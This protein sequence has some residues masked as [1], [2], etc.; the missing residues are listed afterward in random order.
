MKKLYVGNL[1]YTSTE[2]EIRELFENHGEVESVN[3]IM[4]RETG[5]AR[6]FAFVEMN[7][8]GAQ[9]AME[10]LNGVEFG[11]R[12]LKVNEARQREER[13]RRNSW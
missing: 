13:R 2:S 10:A 6:G 9:A 11:G 4:D 8:E 12:A 5:R 1:A 7:D 3:V